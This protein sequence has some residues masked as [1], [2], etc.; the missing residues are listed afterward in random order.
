[1][2]SGT[3]CT[4]LVPLRIIVIR[5]H[6]VVLDVWVDTGDARCTSLL[7]AVQGPVGEVGIRL[8]LDCVRERVVGLLDARQTV[9]G[10]LL[11]PVLAVLNLQAGVHYRDTWDAREVFTAPN[12]LKVAMGHADN[13]TRFSLEHMVQQL[14]PKTPLELTDDLARAHAVFTLFSVARYQKSTDMHARLL[15]VR[16][17]S[18]RLS[19]CGPTSDGVCLSRHFGTKCACG[20]SKTALVA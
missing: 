11:A 4:E 15:A 5:S 18:T 9:C 13:R 19:R 14:L 10:F 1:M 7:Q 17:L 8:P 20:T 12:P 2:A 16:P 6:A 3:C